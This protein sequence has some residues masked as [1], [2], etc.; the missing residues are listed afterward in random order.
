VESADGRQAAL[1][2]IPLLLLVLGEVGGVENDGFGGGRE[3]NQSVTLAPGLEV[4]PK[5]EC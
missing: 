3:R 4:K 1:Q 5:L 2:R